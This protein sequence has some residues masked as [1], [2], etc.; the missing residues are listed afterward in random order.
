MIWVRRFIFFAPIWFLFWGLLGLAGIDP[1]NPYG[2]SFWMGET[3]GIVLLGGVA[4]FMACVAAGYYGGYGISSLYDWFVHSKPP[5]WYLSWQD[6]RRAKTRFQ[7]PK[8]RVA[9]IAP[10]KPDQ[11]LAEAEQE[12]EEMLRRNG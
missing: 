9:E 2:H 7:E 6:K 12:I 5:Q 10:P 8:N 1:R 11:Y 3:L 4:A